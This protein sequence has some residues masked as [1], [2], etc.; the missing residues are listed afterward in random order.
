MYTWVFDILLCSNLFIIRPEPKKRPLVTIESYISLLDALFLVSWTLTH[1][2]YCNQALEV[3]GCNEVIP[4]GHR[5][6]LRPSI[7]WKYKFC[8]NCPT[9]SCSD[10][11]KTNNLF[12]LL[13][14]YFFNPNAP[15]P[16]SPVTNF[17]Y[18][19]SL[20]ISTIN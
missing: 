18:A 1:L 11:N 10:D 17:F 8:V 7:F 5:I 3:G 15:F 2:A 20:L 9:S 12:F 16:P 13:I 4:V 14:N 6:F 19:F